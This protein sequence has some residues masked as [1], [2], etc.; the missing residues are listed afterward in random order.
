VGTEARQAKART[1]QAKKKKKAENVAWENPL[2][3]NARL[4]Q[5]Y[6]AM[7]QARALEQALPAARRGR[8]VVA[9]AKAVACFGLEAALVGAAFDLGAGDQV[10]DALVGGEIDFL[11]GAGLGEVLQP[12]DA[13]RRPRKT[14]AATTAARLAAPS[15]ISERVWAAIGAA[16]ALK[17]AH[18]QTRS[19]ARKQTESDVSEDMPARQAGVVTLFTLPGEAPAILWKAALAFVA[20]ETLPIIFVVL[21]VPHGGSG[22][23]QRTKMGRVSEISLGCGIPAIAVDADDAIAI[24]RVAQES[25]GR[26]RAGGGA[27]LIECIPFVLADAKAARV[28]EKYASTKHTVPPDAI[29]TLKRYLLQ[30]GVAT[31]QWIEREAK[32][33]AR[34]IAK[35][36]AKKAK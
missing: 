17:A 5:V 20:K 27:A 8:A 35:S 2:I 12:S 22:K 21:P 18:A 34:R 16:A 29:A 3:P 7:T 26:A 1:N 19:D 25:I 23:V 31:K 13:R 36:K 28:R 11:R 33:F 14:V 32:V 4:R 24:Y 15:T 10:S 6:L 30:R 9:S